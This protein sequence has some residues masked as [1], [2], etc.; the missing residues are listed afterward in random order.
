VWLY[1]AHSSNLRAGVAWY[2]RLADPSAPLQPKSPLE[3]AAELNAPVLGLYGGAD[4]GIPTDDIELMREAMKKAKKP[5]AIVVYPGAPHGFF[6][7]YRA[8]YRAEVAKDG[9][10]RLRDWFKKYGV[11]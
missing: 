5:C 9:W 8:S 7:D 3:V 4:E 1:A 10:R 11:V 2:G 6:A